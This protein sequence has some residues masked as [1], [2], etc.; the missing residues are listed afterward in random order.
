M[1]KYL[2]SLKLTILWSYCH[3]LPKLNDDQSILKCLHCGKL[4]NSMKGLK[5]HISKSHYKA[6][7]KQI[8]DKDVLTDSNNIHDLMKW[9]S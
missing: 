4:L 5:N 7:R 8:T 2:T 9:N 3:D 1:A 6:H